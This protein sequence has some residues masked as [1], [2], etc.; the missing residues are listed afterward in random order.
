MIISATLQDLSWTDEDPVYTATTNNGGNNH[1]H[2]L[3]HNTLKESKISI[4]KPNKGDE[5][6]LNDNYK[7]LRNN[8]EKNTRKQKA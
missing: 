6:P 3:T 4:N 7:H 1:E 5:S 2:T 8:V